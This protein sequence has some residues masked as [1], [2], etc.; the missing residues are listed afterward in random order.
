[1]LLAS[2][3][4]LAISKSYRKHPQGPTPEDIRGLCSSNRGCRP[5]Y[6]FRPAEEAASRDG[7]QE[8]IGLHTKFG[9]VVS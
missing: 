5:D 1:M 4:A 9:S 6:A 8:A 2:D 7:R 3:P